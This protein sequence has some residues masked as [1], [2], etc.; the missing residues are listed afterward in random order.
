[1]TSNE[2]QWAL[3]HRSRIFNLL[4]NFM[5]V[6]NVSYGG[7]SW[8]E[9]DMIGISKSYYLT[10]GEIKISISDLRADFKKRKYDKEIVEGKM[11]LNDIK[12][13]YFIVPESIADKAFEI[14]QS[15]DSGLIV[16]KKNDYGTYSVFTKIEAK[17][18]KLAKKMSI[19]R[20]LKISR[21]IA[22][23]YWNK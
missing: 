21:L 10:E 1:M 7:F 12:K 4:R 5:V 14:I 13:H 6:P 17:I 2:I 9:A 19:E 11:W 18:N 23:R 8:G 15:T 16:V 3:A 22:F 20:V